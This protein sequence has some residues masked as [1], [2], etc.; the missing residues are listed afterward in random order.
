MNMRNSN[1]RLQA[2]SYIKGECSSEEASSW[3]ALMLSDD[4]ALDVYM[5]VMSEID[6]ELPTLEN[7][8]GFTDGVLSN[9]EIIPY[10]N[11]IVPISSDRPRRWYERP[12]FHYTVAASITLMLMFSGTFDRLF[13]EDTHHTAPKLSQSTSYSKQLMEKTTSWLDRLKP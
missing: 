10:R 3:E 1:W 2:A 6:S 7:L 11:R 8:E 5:Q 12:L 4:A 9:E 13:P